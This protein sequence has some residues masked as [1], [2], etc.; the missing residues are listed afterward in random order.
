VFFAWNRY[1]SD[2]T[3][4]LLRQIEISL[5]SSRDVL[6]AFSSAGDGDAT[7]YK[8]V[9]VLMAGGGLSI[10]IKHRWS[11]RAGDYSGLRRYANITTADECDF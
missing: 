7:Y 4:R 5:S 3:I 8:L 9:S 10:R 6:S 1:S 11:K 2:D